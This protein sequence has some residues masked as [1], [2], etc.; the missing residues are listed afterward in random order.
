MLGY[1]NRR[2]L[3]VRFTYYVVYSK[4]PHKGWTGK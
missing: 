2:K 3:E 1:D 4:N